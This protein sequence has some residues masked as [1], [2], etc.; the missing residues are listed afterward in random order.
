MK[1]A[2]ALYVPVLHAGYLALFKKYARQVESVHL[3]DTQL[4]KELSPH[5]KEIR[6]IKP[7]EM[8]RI[9]DALSLFKSVNV[10]TPRKAR[11][12]A[13]AKY[14]IVTADETISRNFIEKYLPSARVIYAPVFLRWDKAHV[15]VQKP[16]RHHRISRS[17]FDKKIMARATAISQKS[18]D[19]WR[20]VGAVVVKNKRIVLEMHNF[21]VPSEHMPYVYGD[22]RDHIPAG[23]LSHISTA[24]HSEQGIIAE[25]AR[26]EDIG[27]EGA[28]IY[29]TTFPCPVCAKLIAYAGIKRMFFA[30]G[31]SSF[32]GERVLKARD[33]EI[34]LVK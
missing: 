19:W 5:E 16:P 27:L 32:D 20:Q 4:I 30:V 18:S 6:A 28:D 33:V 12:L 10:L 14:T 11:E 22:I 34:V 29:V 8:K 31:H 25:A 13:A 24:F 7:K 2:L 17:A 26:R 21:H 3:F 23:T 15:H 9:I 1:R